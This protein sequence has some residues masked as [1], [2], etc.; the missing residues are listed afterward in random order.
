MLNVSNDISTIFLFLY[1]CYNG[2]ILISSK[3]KSKLK[4][5]P[6]NIRL[7]FDYDGKMAI[8]TEQNARDKIY[9]IY[10]RKNIFKK[11]EFLN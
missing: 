1:N 3:F 7:F 11:E 4:S 2:K 8:W 5:Y 9:L 10:H 6:A